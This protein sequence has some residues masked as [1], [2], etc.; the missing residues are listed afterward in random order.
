[1]KGRK[2]H[3]IVDS[4]GLVLKVIVTEANASERIVTAYALM[5]LLEEGTQL[6][7]S[8]KSMLV[9]QGYR[10]DTFGLAIWLL[11]Q[12]K[13]QVISRSGKSFEVLPKRWIVDRTFSWQ[14]FCCPLCRSGDNGQNYTVETFKGSYSDNES[15]L[16]SQ[17]WWGNSDLAFG[18]LSQVEGELGF[19]N[20]TLDG[21]AGPLFA[22]D[23]SA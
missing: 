4:L 6:L 3:L 20:N 7:E 18:A 14:R 12:A 15:L 13:V 21:I 16:T 8:V 10:G 1:M 5:S 23:F 17:P 11:T 19:P 9:D 2:C 22:F